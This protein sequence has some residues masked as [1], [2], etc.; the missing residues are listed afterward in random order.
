MTPSHRAHGS[1]GIEGGELG[2][3]P[4]FD[5]LRFSAHNGFG[6]CTLDRTFLNAIGLGDFS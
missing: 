4:L 6:N 1:D 5:T 3:L 2:V